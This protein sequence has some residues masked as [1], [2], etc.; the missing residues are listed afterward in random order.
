MITDDHF[1]GDN[2]SNSPSDRRIYSEELALSIAARV[3]STL[4]NLPGAGETLRVQLFSC[5]PV[6]HSI[7]RRLDRLNFV[8]ASK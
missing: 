4:D 2:N 3:L 7:A 5:S 1:H 6:V 8:E